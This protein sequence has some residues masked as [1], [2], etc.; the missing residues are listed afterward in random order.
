MVD[1]K[2]IFSCAQTH[3]IPYSSHSFTFTTQ[4][5]QLF[6]Q[7]IMIIQN[8]CNFFKVFLSHCGLGFKS[9]DWRRQL[10]SLP[11]ADT[12]AH[13]VMSEGTAPPPDHPFALLP[14]SWGI[15]SM[16]REATSPGSQNEAFSPRL[17]PAV[18][19][20]TYHCR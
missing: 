2:F 3:T 8:Q 18:S 5:L 14:F 7:K 9:S 20:G 4:L 15:Y 10:L 1:S 17:L 13:A 6:I 12:C 19:A 16:R 11:I